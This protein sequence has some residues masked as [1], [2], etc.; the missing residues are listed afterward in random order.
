MECGVLT[1]TEQDTLLCCL[2]LNTQLSVVCNITYSIIGTN[3]T[4]NCCPLY[5]IRVL[6]IPLQ[7]LTLKTT[8]VRCM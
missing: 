2:Y 5:I 1:Q 3:L 4:D 8:V 6:H 7:E